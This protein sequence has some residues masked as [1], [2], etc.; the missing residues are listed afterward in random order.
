MLSQQEANELLTTPVNKISTKA[1]I[2]RAEANARIQES[3]H[4]WSRVLTDEKARKSFTNS[5]LET[6]SQLGLDP[7]Y[8]DDNYEELTNLRIILS[9]EVQ[10]HI[11]NNDIKGMMNTLQNYGVIKPSYPNLKEQL[12]T[13]LSDSKTDVLQ[14]SGAQ[15]EN[16]VANLVIAINFAFIINAWAVSNVRTYTLASTE[17]LIFGAPHN[18]DTNDPYIDPE[19]KRALEVINT[20]SKLDTSAAQSNNLLLKTLRSNELLLEKGINNLLSIQTKEFYSAAQEV[21]LF[22]AESLSEQKQINELL[23]TLVKSVE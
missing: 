16:I 19:T 10:F 15:Q 3:A 4:I 14:H 9:D 20:F 18:G 7:S 6:I 23:Q 21:G 2:D 11:K 12:K 8:F 13:I 22:K 5:P 1:L 17:S